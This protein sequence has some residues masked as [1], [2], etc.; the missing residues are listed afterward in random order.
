VSVI[1][2]DENNIR[3]EDCVESPLGL[4]TSIPTTLAGFVQLKVSKTPRG[5]EHR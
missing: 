5:R 3:R 1:S 2:K 4:M